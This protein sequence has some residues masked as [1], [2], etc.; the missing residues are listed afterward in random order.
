MKPKLSLRCKHCLNEDQRMMEPLTDKLYHC[1]VCAKVF[2][3]TNGE[4]RDSKNDSEDTKKEH[5]DTHDS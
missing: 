3:V 2:E 1:S 5:P 4:S